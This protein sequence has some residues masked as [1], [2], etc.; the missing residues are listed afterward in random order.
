MKKKIK[1]FLAFSIALIM[2]LYIAT[3]MILHTKN[4]KAED[5]AELKNMVVFEERDYTIGGL[6][7]KNVYYACVFPDDGSY[8]LAWFKNGKTLKIDNS[9]HK[10]I[11]PEGRTSWKV[12]PTN[13]NDVPLAGNTYWGE[14]YLRL[15]TVDG[16]TII[17]DDNGN[18]YGG[19]TEKY[20]Y[21]DLIS[22]APD[23]Y[24]G[25][26]YT[27]TGDTLKLYDNNSNLIFTTTAGSIVGMVNDYVEI[28]SERYN[29]SSKNRSWVN[30]RGEA[31]DM[32]AILGLSNYY[33]SVH[34]GY[35]LALSGPE[36]K[37]YDYSLNPISAEKK[38]E[39]HTNYLDTVNKRY[40][41]EDEIDSD[42]SMTVP[43]GYTFDK[44]SSTCFSV[45][46]ESFYT[47]K[48]NDS[49]LKVLAREDGTILEELGEFDDISCNA[50]PNRKKLMF[51]TYITKDD[52][53]YFHHFDINVKQISAEPVKSDIVKADDGSISAKVD[54][55]ETTG[56]VFEIEAE[57]GVVPDDSYFSI[58][59]V[60]GGED[61]D[62][63]NESLKDVVSDNN[64]LV[65]YNI[66]LC[67][68]YNFKIQP[69]GKIKITLDKIPKGMDASKVS[70][71]RI[72]AD[73]TKTKIDVEIKNGKL[74]FTT[75]HFSL[76]AIVEEKTEQRTIESPVIPN[77]L[78][79]VEN[80]S[81]NTVAPNTGD[82]NNFLFMLVA[83]VASMVV[84][85][86]YCILNRKNTV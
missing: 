20:D 12:S 65:V 21:I 13:R 16:R 50:L 78:P 29:T 79:V 60:A 57:N 26:F 31:V 45:Y 80:Q 42:F 34:Q 1:S 66:D 56:E 5:T 8:I 25:Y 46:G 51:M 76:Y 86:A 9:D 58:A 22:W 73:G 36:E 75:D 71:Y 82:N 81:N 35:V 18:L 7:G 53:Q 68:G 55:S 33:I 23:K 3:P 10:Y 38:D 48:K 11:V 64:Y 39:L 47:V 77:D 85:S 61:F 72:N 52:I 70:V 44:T 37:Y 40:D 41:G 14:C 59:P 24:K 62:I 49:D 27:V 19:I 74:S 6:N 83:I 43:D 69:N 15:S 17:L 2:G 28:N 63:A 84:I 30:M 54:L 4:V 32:N 67:K